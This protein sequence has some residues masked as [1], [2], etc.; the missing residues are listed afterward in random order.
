MSH[1]SR[2]VLA[3]VAPLLPVIVVSVGC[4][5]SSAGNGASPEG[6][7]SSG[8]GDSGM[9]AIGHEVTLLA[10][11]SG[12]VYSFQIDSTS[13][14]LLLVDNTGSGSTTIQ[15]VPLTGGTP[16]TLASDPQYGAQVA[17][18]GTNVYWVDPNGPQTDA[19]TNAT[20]LVMSVPIGGGPAT[21]VAG[22]Q[23]FPEAVAADDTGVYWANDSQCTKTP[24]PATVGAIMF[25][26]TG[27]TT[28]VELASILSQP[29]SIALDGTNVYWGTTDGRVMKVPKSAATGGAVT[30]LAYYQ[31]SVQGL[32]VAPSGLY[33]ATG[34]GDIMQTPL[35]G[36]ASTAIVVGGDTI[37]GLAV[38]STNL[39]WTTYSNNYTGTT[40]TPASTINELALGGLIAS[41]PTTLWSGNDT[42]DTLQVD[43]SNIYFTTESGALFR[44]TPK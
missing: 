42:P 38:D 24:C 2:V 11:L 41:T 10:T 23:G 1:R 28:P 4:S 12:A 3:L 7:T 16:Q 44:L 21:T 39:Y 31:A 30:Q 18:S 34:T 25:L 37:R 17:V 5:S 13:A 15:K 20:G 40:T 22:A 35:D 9:S 29:S 8:S 6:G 14:Y 43:A 27:S 26:P 32:V 19:S 33:W 36:G